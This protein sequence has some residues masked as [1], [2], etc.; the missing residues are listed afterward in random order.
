MYSFLGQQ[1][2]TRQFRVKYASMRNFIIDAKID[3]IIS[4]LH[5]EIYRNVAFG[6][7]CVA[8]RS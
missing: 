6:G 4:G 5:F 7:V 2:E 1:A 3:Q 8:V